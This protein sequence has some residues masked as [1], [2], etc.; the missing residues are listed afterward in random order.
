[1]RKARNRPRN[2]FF[3]FLVQPGPGV[4]RNKNMGLWRAL[5]DWNKPM[6]WANVVSVHLGQRIAPVDCPQQSNRAH[7]HIAHLRRA[8]HAVF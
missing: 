7:A 2:R 3:G 1:M 6:L 5:M 4:P 8:P